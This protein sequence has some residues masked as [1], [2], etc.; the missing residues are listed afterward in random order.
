MAGMAVKPQVAII[1]PVRKEEETITA[2]LAALSPRIKTP[3]R[4]YVVDDS[5]GPEDRTPAMVARYARTHRQVRLVRKTAA[6]PSGFWEAL[7]RGLLAATEPHIIFVMA[8]SCDLP[9]TIDVMMKTLRRGFDVVS[10]SRYM[11]G[12]RKIGG[13]A[14]QNFFSALVNRTLQLLLQLPTHDATNSFKLI[15]RAVLL[16]HH[17]EMYSPGFEVSLE[18]LL[19]LHFHGYRITEVPTTWYGRTEGVS[20]FKI[21]ERTPKY[22]RLYLLALSKYI[23]RLT[24]PHLSHS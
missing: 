17:R 15:R 19:R 8:D 7:R 5:T 2:T 9:E 16:K 10:G 23:E 11:R 1:I 3:H 18:I 14:V 4:I 6:D 20:K 21:V 12:G 13:P 22:G 24:R